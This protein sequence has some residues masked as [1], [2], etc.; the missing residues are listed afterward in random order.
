[1]FLLAQPLAC[2]GYAA[3]DKFMPAT[4]TILGTPMFMKSKRSRHHHHPQRPLFRQ[5]QRVLH[6][7]Q[8][9]SHPQRQSPAATGVLMAVWR[10]LSPARWKPKITIQAA[11]ALPTTIPLLAMLVASTALTMLIF[12][13]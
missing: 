12:N 13:P 2:L 11:Q 8:P 10:R 3:L 5:R 6:P 4:T 7:Q 9:L 1:M